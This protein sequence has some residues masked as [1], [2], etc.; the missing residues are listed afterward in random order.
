M[1]KPCETSGD[2]ADVGDADPCLGT[3]DGFLPVFGQPATSPEPRL[4]PEPKGRFGST[5]D[6]RDPPLLC[7]KLGDK[8]TKSG[9]KRTSPHEGRLT[10]PGVGIPLNSGWITTFVPPPAQQANTQF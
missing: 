5:T 3:G 9:P 10:A 4:K 7:P 1:T 2:Q 8:Q 6:S